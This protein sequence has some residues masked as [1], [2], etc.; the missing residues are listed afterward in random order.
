MEFKK[1]VMVFGS[2]LLFSALIGFSLAE[3]GTN[4]YPLPFVH[5]G[6]SDVAVVYG[7]NSA[8]SDLNG[9]N[10]INSNLKSF[11]DSY[12]PNLGSGVSEDKVILGQGIVGQ[13]KLRPTFIDNQI[14]SLI[15]GK[16]Y[17]ND[18]LSTRTVYNV[19]EEILLGDMKLKTTLDERDLNGTALTNNKAFG[20][21]YVFEDGLNLSR[22]GNPEADALKINVLGKEYEVKN[23]GNYSMTV[24]TSKEKI[25]SKGESVSFDN[26]T[27]VV[28]DIFGSVVQI[29]NK[30]IHS[31]ETANVDG[32][33]VKVESIAY[34][35]SGSSKVLL[36]FGKEL[37]T[38]YNDGEA[39]IGQDESNPK[40]VW[41]INNPGQVGGYI[42][43]QYNHR[44]RN[45][46][47]N[48][49]Y[50]GEKYTLP[51][52]YGGIEFNGLTEASYENFTV[53]FDD[54]RNLFLAEND[55]GVM[56][57]GAQVLELIGPKD[58]S[59]LVNGINGVNGQV[60]TSTLYL[61]YNSS[62]ET[63]NGSVSGVDVFYKDVNKDYSESV[64]PRFAFTLPNTS[65][66]KNIAQLINKDIT[67]NVSLDNRTLKIGELSIE[68]NPS[69]NFTY[70]GNT[71][72]TAEKSELKI[73]NETVG[74]EKGNIL[75]HKGLILYGSKENS[76]NDEVLFSVPSQQVYGKVSVL[77]R[78]NSKRVK[79]PFG[80]VI[81]KDTE[82]SSVASKNL[83][84]V[85]GSCINS[86]SAN[87]IG[88]SIPLCGSDW[89][90]VTG[91]GAGQYMIKEYTS[92]YDNSKVALLVAGYHAEDTTAAVNK[93][94]SS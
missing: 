84:V 14:P 53:S 28:G 13:G 68:L 51:E 69:G 55:G 12:H 94:I 72:K 1:F 74:N 85:G 77:G 7:A 30:L 22:I 42:G 44:E 87:L 15:D 32:L 6:V 52:N 11:Y 54:S 31:G 4:S 59:F 34:R 33:K 46:E 64:K 71:S 90:A 21:R 89:T 88:S 8:V 66:D 83:I 57:D 43:V 78:E 18:G 92:P 48:L 86:V 23:F 58:N 91:I 2:I 45:S 79:L 67:L 80:S 93:L 70:L 65:T 20:Y 36:R 17:W 41:V 39:Y 60:E 82:V 25:L 10:K 76:R 16:L 37:Y 56:Y 29:N 63:D 5:N 35:S 73:A 27:L 81:V 61:R 47:D 75:S 38:I 24:S 9:A 62:I 3:V 49:V 50:A 40:W 19:H 26:T